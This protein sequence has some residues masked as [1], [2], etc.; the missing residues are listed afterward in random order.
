MTKTILIVLTLLISGCV[1][2]PEK[3]TPVKKY[4]HHW[5]YKGHPIIFK[6]RFKNAKG[7]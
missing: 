1:S 4:D 6:P 3:K 7:I 5:Q 2:M